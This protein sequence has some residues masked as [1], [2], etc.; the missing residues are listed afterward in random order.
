MTQEELV[1]WF[2]SWDLLPASIVYSDTYLGPGVYPRMLS[3][4]ERLGGLD[5]RRWVDEVA[6]AHLEDMNYIR[7]FPE[8]E[9]LWASYQEHLLAP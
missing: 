6:M 1:G 3:E 2:K 7:D 8:W 9:D 4:A 5:F